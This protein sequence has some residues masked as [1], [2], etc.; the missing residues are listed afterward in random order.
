VC[1]WEVHWPSK[2][3][4]LQHFLSLLEKVTV[5]FIEKGQPVSHFED[6]SWECDLPFLA[7]ICGHLNDLNS[8]LQGKCQIVSELYNCVSAFKWHY[9][10]FIYSFWIITLVTF[11]TARKYFNSTRWIMVGMSDTLNSK[12]NYLQT[13]LWTVIKTEDC[14][15]IC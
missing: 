4:V 12:S 2:G 8:Y 1:Y 11:Q 5:F 3:K 14:S 13:D 10:Y 9:H 15:D 6:A 7:D